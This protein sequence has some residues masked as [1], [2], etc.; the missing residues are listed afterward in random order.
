[1]TF[2]G[3]R[4]G[5]RIGRVMSLAT[6]PDTFTSSLWSRSRYA[7]GVSPTSAVT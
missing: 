7:V 6:Q 1:M 2:A 4:P 5:L 3:A